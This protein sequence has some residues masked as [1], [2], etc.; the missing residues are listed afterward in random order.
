M[1]DT[2]HWTWKRIIGTIFGILGIGTLTSCYGVPED[3]E[4]YDIGGK[5]KGKIDGTEQPIKG[6]EVALRG[7]SSTY[8][9]DVSRSSA[10][11]RNGE[12]SFSDLTSGTYTVTYIDVDGTDNGSFKTA[13]KQIELPGSNL[14]L[15]ITLE[16]NE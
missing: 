6:I 15:N 8:G 1:R 9:S 11:N 3:I 14:D 12:F 13:S 4:Y 10:T 7:V 2:I 5:V 16:E